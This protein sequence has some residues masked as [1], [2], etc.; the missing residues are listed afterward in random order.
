MQ[1]CII[2]IINNNGY[3]LLQAASSDLAKIYN[4][5]RLMG[6][7]LFLMM[8]FGILTRY[9]HGKYCVNIS[10]KSR[11]NFFIIVT[12]I[13]YLMLAMVLMI[14]STNKAW[15]FVALFASTL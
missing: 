4:Q 2:G 7:F 5:E 11:A 12:V 3:T 10:H 1:F 14:K 13:S 8:G 9:A 6:L 15:F